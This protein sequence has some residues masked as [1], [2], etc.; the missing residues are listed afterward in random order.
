MSTRGRYDRSLSSTARKKAQRRALILAATSVF[1][2]LG[3]ASASVEEVV[4]EAGMSRRTF[5]E[6]FDDLADVLAA[7]H[8]ASGK[9][10]IRAVELALAAEVDAGGRLRTGVRALLELISENAGLARVLFGDLRAAG[11]RFEV[12]Q[13]KLRGHFAGL[14]HATLDEAHA[15]GELPRAPEPIL[16]LALVAAIEAVGA[17]LAA[18]GGPGLDEATDALVRLARGACR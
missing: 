5:Y 16:V 18:P 8:E 13:E 1:A 15:R 2:R 17:R 6:H 12:R 11:P 10:A 4:R 7:V 3:V 9:L 14:L